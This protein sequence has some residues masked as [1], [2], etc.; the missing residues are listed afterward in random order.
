LALF[1]FALQQL[2]LESFHG[3]WLA[4]AWN[5]C[6]Q[7]KDHEEYNASAAGELITVAATF[8][9]PLQVRWTHC[10]D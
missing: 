4:T 8:R 1:V 6:P 9:N 7:V 3:L 5:G 10:T 2:L